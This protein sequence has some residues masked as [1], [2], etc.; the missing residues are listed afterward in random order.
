MKKLSL[1]LLAFYFPLMAFSQD[2]EWFSQ[3]PSLVSSNINDMHIFNETDAIAVGDDWLVMKTTT[4][5]ADWEILS[6][7]YY[8]L[9][10]VYFLNDTIGWAGGESGRIRK[11]IDGG[12]NWTTQISGYAGTIESLHFVD[13]DTGW[14]VFGGK[15]LKTTDGGLNWVSQYNSENYTS[16]EDCYFMNA[17]TGIVVGYQS[18]G[19]NIFRTTDGGEN[20]TEIDLDGNAWVK[21]VYFLDD[22]LGWAVGIT[23]SYI[24]ISTDEWG[25]TTITIYGECSTVWKTTDG[26]LTWD[27]IIFP[28]NPWLYTVNFID[29]LNG[30]A[31]GEKGI[32]MHTSDGCKTWDVGMSPSGNS[33]SLHSIGLLS[34]SVIIIAGEG[35]TILRSQDN[36]GTWAVISGSGTNK[37]LRAVYSIDPTTAW[38]A[39]DNGIILKTTDGGDYWVTQE[40]WFTGFLN[41]IFFVDGSH[42]WTVGSFGEVVGTTN[43]GLTWVKQSSGTSEELITVCFPDTLHGWAAGKNGTIVNTSNGG[44]DW[45]GQSSGTSDQLNALFFTSHLTGWAVG[46][47][48]AILK[49]TNGGIDWI[50]QVSTTELNLNAAYFTDS[51][52]GWIVGA[53]GIILHTDNGGSDWLPE[54]SNSTSDLVSVSFINETI[55]WTVNSYGEVLKTLNGGK[56]WGSQQGAT[57]GYFSD[58]HF[59]DH[60]TGWMVGNNGVILKTESADGDIIYFPI[61]A[62]PANDSTNL[63]LSVSLKWYQ[64]EG[65]SSYGLQVSKYS[66]FSQTIA[67]ES[68]ITDTVFCLQN[69]DYNTKYYW[70]VNAEYVSDTSK[71]STPWI[72]STIPPPQ[73]PVLIEPG[74][75]ATGIPVKTI[76]KWHAADTALSYRLQVAT[77]VFFTDLIVDESG[78]T[79]TVFALQDLDY[80]MTCYW[81]VRAEYVSD[82]SDWSSDWIFRTLDSPPE[83]P[84][85]PSPRS[86]WD[87]SDLERINPLLSWFESYTVDYYQ[88]QVATDASFTNIVFDSTGIEY[89][90]IQASPLDY[91]TRY[92]WRVKAF[93]AG[94]ESQFSEVYEFITIAEGWISQLSDYYG[95]FMSV[96]FNDSDHGWAAGYGGAIIRTTDGGANWEEVTKASEE[97]L[98][99]TWFADN[100][101]GWVVGDNGI[102]LHTDNGGV[103]WNIQLSG[104]NEILHSI[105]FI[106]ENTG[107]AVGDGGTILKTTNGGQDWFEQ[108]SGKT[109]ELNS[110]FFIDASTG[111]IAGSDHT[112]LKTIDGGEN[113]TD[114]ADEDDYTWYNSVFFV[115]EDQGWLTGFNGMVLKTTDGGDSW[116]QVWPFDGNL[117]FD[118][119]YFV[120]SLNGWLIGSDSELE[121]VLLKTVD[122]GESWEKQTY[123][124]TNN[125]Y[126]IFF[127]DQQTGWLAIGNKI[128]K[129][130][131][132]GGE[133]LLAPVLAEPS[134][135]ANDIPVNPNL[136]WNAATEALYYGL[137]VSESRQFYSWDLVVDQTGITDSYLH[138][139][140]LETYTEYFWRVNAVYPGGT[141]PW[142]IP[143]S[144]TT[145]ETLS[146]DN[147]NVRKLSSFSYPNPFNEGTNICFTL[148][149]DSHV[150]LEIFNIAGSKIETLLKENLIKGEYRIPWTAEDQPAGIYY[151]RVKAGDLFE[152]GKL[153]LMK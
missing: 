66:S 38:A 131:S 62:E 98:E 90:E 85:T 111:W 59:I 45:S 146:I 89:N 1:F 117:F 17:D 95:F 42:G 49:T 97:D 112:L 103:S 121:G 69:L 70:R 141:S 39:G 67:D 63:P 109:S 23:A 2:S 135:K 37:K 48:G 129:T 61:L 51:L 140:D 136:S 56:N 113:W 84:Y 149:A 12:L 46:N 6:T 91:F 147:A 114:M 15:I 108:I 73:P 55:G 3:S 137:Q 142:T 99:D 127:V 77:N 68:G 133:S 58:A 105:H 33:Q 8:D 134:D 19:G 9:A 53:S 123:G 124:T 148:P 4:A 81:R 118:E 88:V 30:W 7:G 115:N 16:L 74:D 52:K 65:A 94:G 29:S 125:I 153:L 26:G 47:N 14:A 93:N 11:T 18:L 5:G 20:W 138:V 143:R 150:E 92:Y 13:A 126:A 21:D 41:D 71:W 79:D 76:L 122:G 24:S 44:S 128:L 102:I 28:L 80:N 100:M 96:Y 119:I 25:S 83:Q 32:I 27:E 36:G 104:I 22:T 86:P 10:S 50:P 75:D 43:G 139:T 145:V 78:I 116:Y 120:D 144:F 151:Y 40:S 34:S 82:T 132:G 35:G 31:A 72:F 110:V 101:N 60:A 130:I 57:S 152:T 106:D 107:W 87:D 64:V 54:V